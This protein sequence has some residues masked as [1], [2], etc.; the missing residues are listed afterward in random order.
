MQDDHH[1]SQEHRQAISI[2]SGSARRGF[3][4]RLCINWWGL[5]CIQG[6]AR[7]QVEKQ[8]SHVIKDSIGRDIVD[9]L[10][11]AG[12]FA[13]YRVA[14]RIAVRNNDAGVFPNLLGIK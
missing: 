9:R 8:R 2:K 14:G 12:T 10:A 7:F 1:G 11:V 13:R 5:R 3:G 4:R 6:H